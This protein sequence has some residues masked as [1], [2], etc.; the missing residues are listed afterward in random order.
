MRHTIPI[1]RD[2]DCGHGY[3]PTDLLPDGMPRCALCRNAQAAQAERM[4]YAETAPDWGMLAS[5]DDS[6]DDVV[7]RSEALPEL[8]PLP[9][10]LRQLAELLDSH[11]DA[12]DVIREALAELDRPRHQRLRHVQCSECQ[13]VFPARSS[14]A[15]TCSGACRIRRS[16]RLRGERR[17]RSCDVLASV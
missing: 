7:I 5:G 17:D 12:F 9:D 16:Y 15:R 14:Q 3:L 11:P 2:D 13:T 6:D 10:N 1:T 4:E 8:P